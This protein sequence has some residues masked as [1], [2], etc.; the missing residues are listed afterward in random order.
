MA[1]LGNP[2]TGGRAP[3]TPNRLTKSVKDA[4]LTAFDELG[5]VNYLVEVG[6]QKPE[7]FCALLAKIL[8]TQ[9]AGADGR[10]IRI[11]WLRHEGRNGDESVVEGEATE[12]TPTLACRTHV[13]QESPTCRQA[14]CIY[15]EE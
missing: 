3:G 7:V 6:R 15:A 8:P 11:S 9:L 5:G 13:I 12:L 14:A 4:I 1:G 10:E 2:K